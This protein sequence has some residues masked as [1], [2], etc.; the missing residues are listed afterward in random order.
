MGVPHFSKIIAV[1]L[2][3]FCLANVSHGLRTNPSSQHSVS[4]SYT[5]YNPTLTNHFESLDSTGCHDCLMGYV[6][7]NNNCSKCH[8]DEQCK[9][10]MGSQAVCPASGICQHKSLFHN[11]ITALDIVGMALLFLGC[12]LS[13]GGGV[14]GGGIYIPILILVNKFSPKTAIPLSNC[15]VAGCSFANLIQNFPRRHPHANKHLIDYSVVLLIEPLTLGGTVFGIYLHTVLPPY[16]ILILLVVTLTATSATTFK[17]GLDLRKKENTKKEY[18]LINNNSDAYLTPEKKVNPF[19]DADW[20]KIFAILS[21][22]IL[23]TMFSV[24]KGGDS[25]VSLIGIKLCSPP[26]WV[27]SF[28]IWPI[29][30]ITW[31]FTARYLY[32]QWLRNQADGT[33]IEGDI[34]YSRKTIILLGILSVVAGILASL[35]GIG[36]GMI[37]GPVLLAMGL[38]PDIVAAT[39]SFMILFTSASSAFQY[40]LL[41]KLRLDYGLVYY[42]IGFAAC[43]VGTQ[44]LIWVVNKY[45]KRSYIIF[46]IT[47][48]IVISTILLVVTEVLDLEKY[49][50]QPFQSICSP[51][52]GGSS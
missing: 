5:A 4:N 40:I 45:K 23:S 50:N 3:I 42:I 7:I 16:V 8:T 41:G 6:C 46:L 21:I 32:G 48:I 26:Y 25:E 24:F 17:K 19:L 49:K 38:S 22:L 13:S 34:R 2:I 14:G 39:S 30:I 33:I 28:A 29:I 51:G 37:K 18:L 1:T 10:S 36:G 20:V 15:L 35:L 52:S 27:L 43:F 31:I 44:T 47:A 11:Q 9:D 12:A